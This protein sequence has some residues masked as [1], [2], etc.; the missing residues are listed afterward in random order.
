MEYPLG[1]QFVET[2]LGGFYRL[3]PIQKVLR[4]YRF[5]GEAI[6][7]EALPDASEQEILL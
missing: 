4:E 2:N 1:T 6:I 5:S 7:G 3:E